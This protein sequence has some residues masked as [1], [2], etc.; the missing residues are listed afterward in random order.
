MG[1]HISD[2]STYHVLCYK[3]N[4]LFDFLRGER[5]RE[6]D[7]VPLRGLDG[8]TGSR[9]TSTFTL[10][11]KAINEDGNLRSVHIEFPWE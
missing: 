4:K 1:K 6:E 7:E 5:I 10:M 2:I 3:S 9:Y 8:S 11:N